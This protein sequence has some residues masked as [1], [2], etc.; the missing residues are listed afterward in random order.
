[1]HLSLKCNKKS[2]TVDISGANRQAL[3]RRLAC[4]SA[5]MIENYKA[6][7]LAKYGL[8]YAPIGKENPRIIYC[9]V[10]GFGQ[11]RPY[12]HRAGYD[13]IFMRCVG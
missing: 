4:M 8:D 13:P 7:D 11:S 3:V 2:I 12:M 1:M 5:V 10:T 6:C 9:S